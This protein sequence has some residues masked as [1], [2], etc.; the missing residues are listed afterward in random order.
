[1][2]KQE[3]ACVVLLLYAF[4]K[5]LIRSVAQEVCFIQFD[6]VADLFGPFQ[7]LYIHAKF[8]DEY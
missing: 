4:V 3:I 7:L 6:S 8:L 1:M 2:V 5:T